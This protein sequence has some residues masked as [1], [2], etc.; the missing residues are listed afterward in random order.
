MAKQWLFDNL[1]HISDKIIML[2]VLNGKSHYC[3]TID[4]AYN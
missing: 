3:T 4:D 2:Y 1:T